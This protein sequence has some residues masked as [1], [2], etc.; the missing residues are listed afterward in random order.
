MVKNLPTNAGDIKRH[1]LN[2]WVKKLSRRRKWQPTPIFWTGESFGQRSLTG[3][4]HRVAKRQTQMKQLSM[5][6]CILWD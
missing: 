4:S 3:Y 2:P 5:N 1:G 6:V